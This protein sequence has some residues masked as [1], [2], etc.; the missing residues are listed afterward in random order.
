M[1][2]PANTLAI[3]PEELQIA[4]SRIAACN[5]GQTP[6][7]RGIDDPRQGA[8]P[9]RSDKQAIAFLKL[10]VSRVGYENSRSETDKLSVLR[11]PVRFTNT[12]RRSAML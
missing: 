7:E 11:G 1:G 2:M 6:V 3:I 12:G 5:S 10:G 8:N 4:G 9:I